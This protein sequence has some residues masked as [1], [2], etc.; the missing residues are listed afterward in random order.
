MTGNGN[1]IPI[2]V[3]V[4]AFLACYILL[5]AT[6]P[7]EFFVTTKEYAQLSV[8]EQFRALDLTTLAWRT[9]NS[10]EPSHSWHNPRKFFL[11]ETDSQIEVWGFWENGD[12]YFFHVWVKYFIVFSHHMYRVSENPD[13][14]GVTKDELLIAW[15]S[16]T[17]TS[18]LEMTCSCGTVYYVYLTFNDTE[19]G[20][21]AEAIDNHDLEA[22]IGV[23][24]EDAVAK[25]STWG[26]VG[27][28]LMFQKPDVFPQGTYGTVLNLLIAL[29]FYAAIAILIVIIVLMF[30]PFT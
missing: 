11:P 14:W 13:Y 23:G 27:Q 28:L 6:I 29:P 2:F 24:L 5:V 7:V 9:N 8:P 15:D 3:G 22:L 12:L 26:I 10:I 30:I 21:F 18:N 25:I 16:E 19:Y 20:S 1:L 4:I 17:N